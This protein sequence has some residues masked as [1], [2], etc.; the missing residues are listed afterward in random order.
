MA[1]KT[2]AAK[3]AEEIRANVAAKAK[4]SV[5]V[6]ADN[7]E[8]RSAITRAQQL[9]VDDGLPWQA[10]LTDEQREQAWK[11]NPPKPASTI[12]D[13]PAKKEVP[14]DV[15]A[16]AAEE[17]DKK[18][19]QKKNRIAKMVNKSKAPDPSTHRWDATKNKWVPIP[20]VE[21]PKKVKP[22]NVAKI[23]KAAEKKA[24]VQKKATPKKAKAPSAPAK[25]KSPI[26]EA[27][28]LRTG[29][30]H[31]TIA[32]FLDDKLGKM[33]TEAAIIKH[34]YNDPA[35]TKTNR[36]KDLMRIMEDNKKYEM[37]VDTKNGVTSYGLYLKK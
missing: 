17:A 35:V 4:T 30:K 3:L 5:Q 28:G 16:F 25:D 26:A 9:M 11:D 10:I 8:E 15:L 27:L 23:K 20:G 33:I 6:Q 24:G 18:N 14:A 7:A 36:I 19:T 32:Q 12:N 31:E 22:L 1:K 34:V 21:Q 29:S 37:K 13:G 2:K